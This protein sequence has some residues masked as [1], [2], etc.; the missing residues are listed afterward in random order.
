MEKDELYHYGVL[1]M[2]W[3]VRKNPSLTYAKAVKKKQKLDTKA[4][5]LDVKASKLERKSVKKEKKAGDSSSDTSKKLH[6]KS[7]NVRLKADKFKKKSVRWEKQMNRVF[8]D[9]TVE[10]VP[11]SIVNEGRNTVQRM[12]YGDINYRVTAR[13]D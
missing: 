5:K 4:A 9:Y 8:S 3:G 2:K 12:L 10:R 11:K 13:N 7:V 6:E 1:G